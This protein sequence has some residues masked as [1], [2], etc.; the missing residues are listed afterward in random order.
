MTVD[1]LG[2]AKERT[3]HSGKPIILITLYPSTFV[4]K[5]NDEREIC[6]ICTSANRFLKRRAIV[7]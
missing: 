6:L 5:I 4:P 1:L 3:T 2:D 7:I